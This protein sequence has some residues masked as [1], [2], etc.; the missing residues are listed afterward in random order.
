MN[1]TLKNGGNIIKGA[2][3]SAGTGGAALN[4]ALK[5]AGGGI[6]TAALGVIVNKQGDALAKA[7]NNLGGLHEKKWGVIVWVNV[8]WEVCVNVSCCVF[9]DKNV[10]DPESDWYSPRDGSGFNGTSE[11]FGLNETDAILAS[12][13]GAIKYAL[14]QIP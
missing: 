13:P 3:K 9:W 5:S 12:I 2:A 11:G 7:A 1:K 4:G 8:Y 14:S 10:W 6:P